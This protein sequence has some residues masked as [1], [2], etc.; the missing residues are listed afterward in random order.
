MVNT[1]GLISARDPG[2][3]HFE[4][5]DPRE[6]LMPFQGRRLASILELPNSSLG[7][8]AKMAHSICEAFLREDCSL[9]EINPLVLTKGGDLIALD[10][11]MNF[12]DNAGFRHPTHQE[13]RDLDEEEPMEVR[14][15][16]VGLSYISM[17][18]SIGCMVNGAG[19]AMATM[20]IIKIHGG[21]PANFLDVGG[22]ATAER[23]T[24]AFRIILSDRKVES[25]L[26][27]IFGGIVRC[28]LIAKGI[29]DAVKEA[30]IEDPLIVRLEGNMVDEGKKILDE[31]GLNI[32]AAED[33][34]DAASKAVAAARGENR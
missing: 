33:L 32:I 21:E 19:L 22:D 12:D 30:G 13:L 31:S 7:A 25:I 4:V 34:D 5:I 28:D 24:E 2:A 26:V 9:A 10:A 20:D 18:G 11:K 27:N 15:S 6:G 3:I 14:A 16:Q 8:F 29:V 1:S 23:V 17:D